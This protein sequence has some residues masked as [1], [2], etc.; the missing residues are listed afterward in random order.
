[1]KILSGKE[2]IYY[3]IRKVI[4]QFELRHEQKIICNTN[5]ENYS[6]I[7]KELSAITV[8]LPYTARERQHQDYPEPSVLEQSVQY[9]HRK[10]DLTGGQIKDVYFGQVKK[11]RAHLVD[12]CYIYLYGVGRL[13]FENDP[14]DPNLLLA[15]A[16]PEETVEKKTNESRRKFPIYLSGLLI[17]FTG[18]NIY[19]WISTGRAKT[20][21]IWTT[22]QPTAEEVDAVTGVWLYQTGAPQARSNEAN[23]FRRYATN[24]VVIKQV[25]DRL[26]MQRHGATIN[27]QGYVEFTSPGTL[28]IHSYV[29]KGKDGALINPSHSL[30]KLHPQDSIMYTISS[31]WSFESD[32]NND[33]IGARN[34]YTK[35]GKGGMLHPI[36]NTPENAACHCKIVEWK[37]NDGSSERFNL[38]YETIQPG[39]LTED[40]DESSLIL[41]RPKSG[42]LLS[43]PAK[44][45][46]S[47]H[48]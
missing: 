24:I 16:H 48:I 8:N 26:M 11:P 44:N 36:F 5:R 42:V 40:L 43:K 3:L 25:G 37:R 47:E 20:E 45:D 9:P 18:I 31:T 1:M 41:R 14:S 7:A 35:L 10:Y 4:E 23:R 27:H 15:E 32:D 38:T 46:E 28:S 39:S 29:E 19:L 22:Y 33:I 6:A 2:E 30:A 17:L 13:G 21:T 34:I 12:A